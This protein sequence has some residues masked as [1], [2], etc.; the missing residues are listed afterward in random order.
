MQQDPSLDPLAFKPK[1]K[2]PL[3]V[4]AVAG[5]LAG[6]LL[7]ALVTAATVTADVKGKKRGRKT[8]VVAETSASSSS[9]AAPAGSG[10]PKALAKGALAERAAKGDAAAV[11]QL[12]ARPPE[13]RSSEETLA[14]EAARTIAKQKEIAEL[15]RKI[16]LVPKLIKEDKDVKARMAEFLDDRSVVPDLIRAYAEMSGEVGADLLYS[17][18]S[19]R[20]DKETE[21]LAEDV[22]YSKDVRAKTSKAL[23]V[24]L[25]LRK[26]EKCDGVPKLLERA[27]SDGDRRALIPLMRFHQKRGCGEK[28]LDDCWPCVR[29][30]DLLKDAMVAVQRRSPP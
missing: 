19:G 21:R 29:E 3:I 7:G 1:T 27:K 11:K 26:A 25:D 8:D 18:V 30:G 16:G 14:L 10:A 12:E 17:I 5:F 23:A 6:A 9:S 15:T 24:I 22:L 13:M 4:A 20:N 28:K 2:V